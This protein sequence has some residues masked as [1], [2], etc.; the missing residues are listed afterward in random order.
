MHPYTPNNSPDSNPVD[1]VFLTSL[2]TVPVIGP[3]LSKMYSNYVWDA[4][5]KRLEAFVDELKQSV[6]SLNQSTTQQLGERVKCLNPNEA[7]FTIDLQMILFKAVQDEPFYDDKKEYF[8]KCFFQII[9]DIP[10]TYEQHDLKA[11]FIEYLSQLK[12]SEIVILKTLELESKGP[13]GGK[14]LN[15]NEIA[16]KTNLGE[17]KEVLVQSSIAKLSSLGLSSSEATWDGGYRYRLSPLGKQ[18]IAFCLSP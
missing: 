18:F 5:F 13:A 15:F 16:E 2:E 12:I 6:E 8:K 4:R 10:E 7:K 9:E 11:Y 14:S 1:A 3:V 17:Y